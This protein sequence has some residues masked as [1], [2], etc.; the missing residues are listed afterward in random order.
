MKARELAENDW[1]RLPDDWRI[2]ERLPGPIKPI[3][4]EEECVPVRP[5]QPTA[6]MLGVYIPANDDVEPCKKQN[7]LRLA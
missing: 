2:F 6:N 4:D 7:S 3:Q 5:L 1:F